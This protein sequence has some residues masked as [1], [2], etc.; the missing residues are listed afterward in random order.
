MVS[1][2]GLLQ[3]SKLG[4]K[5]FRNHPDLEP[6]HMQ[7]S[8]VWKKTVLE[9]VTYIEPECWKSSRSGR[10]LGWILEIIQIWSH[11]IGNHPDLEE[12]CQ[13][14]PPIKSQNV[15]N[16]PDLEENCQNQPPII[17]IHQVY[18]VR[19]ERIH[20]WQKIYIFFLPKLDLLATYL[21]DALDLV[22]LKLVSRARPSTG[23]IIRGRGVTQSAEKRSP[24]EGLA[25]GY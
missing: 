3:S 19:R 22:P 6:Q 9:S 12:N 10:K 7:S 4:R 14:Q 2:C 11:N 23:E 20:I 18:R 16:H 25:G 15:G 17:I 1:H 8:R 13:N 24:V 21:H 5:V